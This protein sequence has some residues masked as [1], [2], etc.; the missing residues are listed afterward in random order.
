MKR[1][2]GPG[3]YPEHARG[4]SHGQATPHTPSLTRCH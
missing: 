2:S 1:L 3:K 4:S